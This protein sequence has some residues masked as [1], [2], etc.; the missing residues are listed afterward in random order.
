MTNCINVN[1]PL[2]KE[3]VAAFNGNEALA[4]TAVALNKDVIPS[5]DEAKS[6]IA[7]MKIEENDERHVR[8]SDE[9]KLERTK[10]QAVTLTNLSLFANNAQKEAISKLLQNNREYQE[11][12]E[13]NI[14]LRKDGRNTLPSYSVTSFIGSSDFKGDPTKFEAFK[15]FGTFM[16]DVLEKAQVEALKTQKNIDEVLRRSYRRRHFIRLCSSSPE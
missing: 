9:F 12:L 4:R 14:E 13:K 1:D 6:L 5:V 11:F 3:L 10:E 2:F 8:H 15:L 7:N 16:H